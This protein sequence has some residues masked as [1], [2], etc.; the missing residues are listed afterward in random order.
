MLAPIVHVLGA[1]P[2]FVKAAPVIARARAPVGAEQ[3]V[4]HTGQHYDERMSEVFF[5]S[6]ACPNP[7]STSASAPAATPRRPPRSWSRWRRSSRAFT[8][9]RHGVRRRELDIAAALVAAKLQHPG[10]PR[11]GRAAQLR[12]DHAGGGQPASSP[13]SSSDL[14]FVTS[15]EAVG[16]LAAEGVRRRAGA[17]RRQP[18]DRHA[19]RQPRHVR[20]RARSAPRTALPERGT[21][22]RPCTGPANVDDPE[23]AAGAGQARCTRS[24][25]CCRRR[26]A[27]APARPG[28]PAGRRARRPPAA[29]TSSSRSATSTS[30]P[31]YAARPPW[32]PT[33]GGVQEETTILGVPCLTLRPNTERPITITHGTNRLVTPRSWCPPAKGLEGEPGSAKAP[34]RSRTGRRRPQPAAV[35]RPGRPPHRTK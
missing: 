19:A 18:D 34:R 15:P 22:S 4:V 25:T 21:S 7:T 24:P 13:T 32:S 29:C 33:P 23:A 1:R 8:R 30:S 31:R 12:H 6:S 5:A 3:A 26:H 20:H 28:E 17:L 10:R 14:L 2:N 11:R 27:R 35:G 9:A 16:H